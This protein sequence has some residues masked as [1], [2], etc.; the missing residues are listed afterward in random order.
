MLEL[1]AKSAFDTLPQGRGLTVTAE[2]GLGIAMVQALA[3]QRAEL[4]ARLSAATG[5]HL[6]EG[7]RVGHAEGLTALGIGPARWLV[8]SEGE[9]NG[10]APRLAA[11]MGGAGVVND[12]SDGYAVLR[13]TGPACL[14]VLARGVNIDLHPTAFPVGSVAAT[15][16]AHLGVILWRAPDADGAPVFML[17]VFRSMAGSLVHWLETAIAGAGLAGG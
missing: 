14:A 3:G 1:A 10:L 8:L 9:A 4:S 5:L 16:I 2:H 7:P 17:A 13:L 15:G 12:Q 11:A 6:P